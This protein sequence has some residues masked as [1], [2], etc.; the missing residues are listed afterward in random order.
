MDT[1]FTESGIT[2]YHKQ[3]EQKF[4]EHAKIT[5]VQGKWIVSNS[6]AILGHCSCGSSFKQK[7]GNALQDKAEAIKLKLRQKSHKHH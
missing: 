3:S 7:T 6:G 2:F 5:K 1:E 4:F